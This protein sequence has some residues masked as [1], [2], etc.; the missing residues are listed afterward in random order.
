MVSLQPSCRILK[1][2]DVINVNSEYCVKRVKKICLSFI[3]YKDVSF[4]NY[5]LRLS[6]VKNVN[7]DVKIRYPTFNGFHNA[8]VFF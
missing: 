7:F 5:V 3:H 1:R 8:Y 4:K 2:L 6:C